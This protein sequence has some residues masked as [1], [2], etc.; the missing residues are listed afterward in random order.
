MRTGERRM[1]LLN[2]RF[3]ARR[4]TRVWG[5]CGTGGL[6]S[7]FISALGRALASR[8]GMLVETVKEVSDEAASQR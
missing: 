4:R 7:A 1:L 6:A 3:S 5:E 8:T 2:A